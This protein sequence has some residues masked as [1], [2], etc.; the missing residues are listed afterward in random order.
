MGNA[1]EFCRLFGPEAGRLRRHLSQVPV[2]ALAFIVIGMQGRDAEA[3]LMFSWDQ[4]ETALHGSYAVDLAC[5]CTH[6]SAGSAATAPAER[7][8]GSS[9]SSEDL[10]STRTHDLPLHARV[11]G[12]AQIADL[13]TPASGA[14]AP[15]NGS[16]GSGSLGSPAALC[17][18]V[19]D[20]PMANQFHQ[21]CERSPRPPLL[22]AL[23]LLDPPKAFA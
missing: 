21:W 17:S 10:D 12:H 1:Q 2:L 22:P 18:L 9:S 7:S 5:S 8:A 4:T 19:V 13:T 16:I 11:T 3:G 14:S 23:E 20:L 6:T 15:V